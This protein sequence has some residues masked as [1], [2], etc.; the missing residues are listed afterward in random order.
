MIMRRIKFRLKRIFLYIAIIII[1]FCVIA[2]FLWTIISSISTN[3]ELLSVPVHFIPENPTFERYKA[4]FTSDDT[5]VVAFKRGI[6]NSFIV[7]SG[8]TIVC[9]VIGTFA[10][11]AFARLKFPRKNMTLQFFLFTN[12]IPPIVIIIAI[13]FIFSKL[14]M[15]DS[16]ISLILLYSSFITP[17]VIWMMRSY[18]VTIPADLE[19]A[20]MIDGCN[21][22]GALFRII[23]PLSTPGLVANGI[24][25][26]LMSWE[27]F[28][29][30]LIL[31]TSKAKTITVAIAEFTGKQYVD[32]GL[33][34][35]GGV[36]G[37]IIPVLITLIFGRYII[38]GLTSGAVKG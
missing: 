20:A 3:K 14:D 18:F 15:L 8:V 17:F 22:I 24:L 10:G 36:I 32:Y 26:F 4:I 31:T 6:I 7:S 2:P 29:F 12:M 37:A 34:A 19:E 1:M 13:Y 16:V 21:R 11:Y 9:L 30:A 5:K 38:K 28:L 35:T 23:I 33:M 25:A 27:E